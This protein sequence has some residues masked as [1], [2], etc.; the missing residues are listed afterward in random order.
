[1]APPAGGGEEGEEAPLEET[2]VVVEVRGLGPGPGL[3]GQWRLQLSAEASRPGHFRLELQGSGSPPGEGFQWPLES[4]ACTSRSPCELELQP[5]KEGSGP[6]VLTLCFRDTQDA[7]RWS[8]LLERA[9]DPALGGSA[10]ASPASAPAPGILPPSISTPP[11]AS[12]AE[13]LWSPQDFSEKEELANRLTQAICGGDEQGAAQ[14]A[15]ALAQRQVPLSILLQE[16]C[17]PSGPI[18]VQVTVEDAASSAHISLRVHPHST[19]AALQEQVFKEYGFPPRVQRWVIGRCLCVP[20]R[21]L[22]SYGVQRDGDPAFLYLLSGPPGPH[23]ARPPGRGLEAS[24]KSNGEISSLLAQQPGLPQASSPAPTNPS[25]CLQVG[26]SCPSCT[27]INVPGRPGC[28]MC[29]TEQPVFR[30]PQPE[31]SAQQPPKITRRGEDVT[32]PPSI[33]S[34]DAFLHLSSEFS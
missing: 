28:E 16:S 27:F 3:D 19:I 8:A 1:M 14:A 24:K 32:I 26:W 5:P 9:R 15:A 12:E 2:A 29:S 7:Q 4:V 6:G 25:G 17:F 21:S 34:L 22:A 10:V 31:A 11:P 13:S 20:E 18:R 23:S 33:G 30:S